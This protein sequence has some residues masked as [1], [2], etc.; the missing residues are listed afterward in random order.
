MLDT[1][2]VCYIQTFLYVEL[3]AY[4]DDRSVD[5]VGNVADPIFLTQDNNIATGRNN[6]MIIFNI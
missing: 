3:F 6:I 2:E 5:D 1:T 4:Q